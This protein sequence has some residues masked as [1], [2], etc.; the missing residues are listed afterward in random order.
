MRSC[1]CGS[2]RQSRQCRL[3]PLLEAA[4]DAKLKE[5]QL[6]AIG[7]PGAASPKS[8]V[9]AGAAIART[10][11]E[12]ELQGRARASLPDVAASQVFALALQAAE[13]ADRELP[14]AAGKQ[15]WRHEWLQS[16]GAAEQ[17]QA[18]MEAVTAAAAVAAAVSATPAGVWNARLASP[19]AAMSTNST[20]V[21]KPSPFLS[22]ARALHSATLCFKLALTK[23][24]NP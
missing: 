18:R 1:P 16:P 20:S 23:P 22:L 2:V 14:G 15:K 11:T 3:Q 9:L 6:Y 19:A 13:S 5:L 10:Y 4:R 17:V 12:A 8:A 21:S 7:K 24:S